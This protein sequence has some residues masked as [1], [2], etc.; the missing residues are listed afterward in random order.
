VV[1]GWAPLV[2][3]VAMAVARM[4]P[5]VVVPE[6]EAA[7]HDAPGVATRAASLGARLPA[8][9]AVAV[10]LRYLHAEIMANAGEAPAQTA[11][12]PMGA[13]APDMPLTAAEAAPRGACLPVPATAEPP[14]MAIAT[15][16]RGACLL[17]PALAESPRTWAAVAMPRGWPSAREEAP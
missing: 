5:V 6:E 9:A 12:M 4:V 3:A 10:L 1:M 17:A 16:P 8:A 11:Q 15:A 13:A 2:V 7:A 14:V